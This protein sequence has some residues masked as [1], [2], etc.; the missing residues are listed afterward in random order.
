MTFA[1]Y[2]GSLVEIEAEIGNLVNIKDDFLQAMV[3]KSELIMIPCGCADD[4][5]AELE[6]VK[7]QIIE[8]RSRMYRLESEYSKKM[9]RLREMYMDERS[10]EMRLVNRILKISQESCQK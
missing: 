3:A 4:L 7:K 6:S 5:L 8:V 2:Q 1:I 10:N 9:E